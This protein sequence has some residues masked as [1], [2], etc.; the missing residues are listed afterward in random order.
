MRT[1]IIFVGGIHG[2]GKGTICKELSRIFQFNH[3]SASDVLKWN[4]ISDKGNKNVKNL[5]STQERLI[6]GLSQIIEPAKKYL[7]D[8]H[9]CLL[10]SDGVP[11]KVPENTF[12][13]IDPCAIIVITC[14]AQTIADRLKAR[15]NKSY[16]IKILQEM[17]SLEV[18]FAQKISLQLNIPFFNIKTSK[19]ALLL[20]FLA[21][22]ENI[23]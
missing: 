4:E 20:D 6:Y 18:E 5:N 23:N 10:N 15:D 7:L 2:V 1:N 21:N 8:G 3:L 14:N 12:L 13:K 9:F 19:D 16:D 17:Q 22:Y 11:E